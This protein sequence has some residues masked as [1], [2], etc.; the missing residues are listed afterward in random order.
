MSALLGDG[1]GN[2]TNTGLTIVQRAL[3]AGEDLSAATI[4]WGRR[5]EPPP[6]LALTDRDLRLM[7]LL[8]G[9]NFLSMSH[10]T[11]L[12]W[13]FSRKRAAQMRL[14]KSHGLA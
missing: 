2:M 1:S 5:P 12:G 9:A 11:A 4:S 14:R 13:G 10:L 8:Y 7:A 6:R 3:L